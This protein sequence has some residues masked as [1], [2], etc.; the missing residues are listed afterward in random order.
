[1]Q[2]LC[3]RGT[4][5]LIIITIICNKVTEY[6]YKKHRE[7]GSLFLH[8]QLKSTVTTVGVRKLE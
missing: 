7:F 1:M 8:T 4:Y 2:E 6:C 5:H 3:A